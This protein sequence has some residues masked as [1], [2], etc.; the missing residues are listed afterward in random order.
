MKR[1]NH[2]RTIEW[3]VILTIV[4]VYLQLLKVHFL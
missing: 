4:K 2:K 3:A 1:K